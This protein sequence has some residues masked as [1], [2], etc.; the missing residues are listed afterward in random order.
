M[1]EDAP[2]ITLDEVRSI[3]RLANLELE[4]DEL[5]RMA[6]ELGDILAYVR[7]LTEVDVTDVPPTMG[8]LRG[9]QLSA[10]VLER[11]TS[12]VPGESTGDRV[13]L[14]PDAPEASLPAEL[15]LRE[16]PRAHD[17]GFAVPAFVDEG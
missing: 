4:P 5:S 7:Q 14:R 16:A 8:G 11:G 10:D 17:G 2:P 12:A 1:A 15:A 3:A 6:R 13:P 9:A